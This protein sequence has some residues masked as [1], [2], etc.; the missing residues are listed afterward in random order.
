MILPWHTQQWQQLQHAKQQDRLAHAFLFAGVAG[1]GK[2]QFAEAFA[3]NL[4][5]KQDC[6]TQLCH[7][8]RLIA[9]KTHP[10]ILWVIPEKPGQAI[11]IDQIREANEFIQQSSMYDGY[12]LLLLNP[13]HDMNMNAANALLKSLEEPAA[14]AVIILISDQ[15]SRLPATI[16]SRCQRMNFVRPTTALAL[17]WL[18]Q[19]LK[20]TTVD[21]D[22]LLCLTQ[23]SPLAALQLAETDFFA[24][25][26]TVLNTLHTFTDPIKAVAKLPDMEPLRL[27]DMLLSWAMD[28]LHLQLQTGVLTNLD[29]QQE[30][31]AISKRMQ[32]PQ[33][34]NL[35]SY[36]QHVRKVICMGINLNKQLLLESVFIRWQ[37]C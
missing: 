24:E 2:A 12:R 31:S 32:M 15:P 34:L 5:C 27:L 16:L 30:L 28:I 19:H 14:G 22:L 13:A 18:R 8:C 6:T 25:R 1:V 11:K 36:L 35:L 7:S 9:A 37:R 4:L 20:N 33:T 17:S 3:Q 10:N 21:V 23:G 26:Q 29:Y